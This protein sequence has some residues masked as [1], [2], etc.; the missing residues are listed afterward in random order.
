MSI[1]ALI[2]DFGGTLIDESKGFEGPCVFWP[3]ID[4]LP[5]VAETVPEL[6]R[7]Y[8]LLVASNAEQSNGEMI[9]AALKRA[10]IGQHFEACYTPKELDGA[11]KPN[12]EFLTRILEQHSLSLFEAVMVG[13]MY[14]TDILG[15]H[16]AGMKSIWLN[17]AQTPAPALTPLCTAS[18]AN[19]SELSDVLSKP[20]LPD[21]PEISGL[22]ARQKDSFYLR[23]HVEMVASCAY[24]MAVLLA[25]NGVS[26]NTILAHRGGYLHDLGKISAAEQKIPHDKVGERILTEAGWPLL[27]RI[28]RS[29]MLSNLLKDE[30]KPRTIEEK[31]V[32]IA[33]KMIINGQLGTIGERMEGLRTRYRI[34]DAEMNP[35]VEAVNELEGELCQLMGIE[36]AQLLP[37][38]ESMFDFAS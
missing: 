31:V 1:Q 21:L 38:L 13:D 33:D 29:H 17:P 9:H 28:A 7:K 16:N 35:I 23:A 22:Y 8:K 20:F 5:G 11:R 27:G 4:L 2:F 15:A 26:I 3:E 18:L 19:F 36:Q 24:A 32:Y 14:K 25:K 6:G 12:R 34:S 10:G 37:A 30:L